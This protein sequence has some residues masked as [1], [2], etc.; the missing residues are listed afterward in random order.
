ME[1]RHYQEFLPEEPGFKES[2]PESAEQKDV[3]GALS[4]F[5]DFAEILEM[6]S[7]EGTKEFT[8]DERA[9][10]E[11]AL[12]K[13]LEASQDDSVALMGRDVLGKATAACR[14][15]EVNFPAR[16]DDLALL[17]M[18]L[19][20]NKEKARFGEES[21]SHEKEDASEVRAEEELEKM[22]IPRWEYELHA[23]RSGGKGGQ[24]VN[25]V[26][27]KMF[28]RFSVNDST[29]FNEAEK[30]VI[31]AELKLTKNGEL[32]IWEQDERYQLRNR[33]H[34]VEKLHDM[35]R[36]ALRTKAPRIATRPTQGSVRR[37]LD[38]KSLH[39]KKKADRKGKI[40][41]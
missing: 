26:E 10:L 40:E 35:V 30:A 33:M 25:K 21:G 41:Y 29:Y 11:G 14:A 32:V 2:R 7:P 27:T 34:V 6:E 4:A 12:D 22:D 28:L 3:F 38:E 5:C 24:N 39:G 13:A 37:R 15:F 23:S 36:E 18:R 1:N 9:V 17:A 20:V 19:S 8:P 16:E 31:R